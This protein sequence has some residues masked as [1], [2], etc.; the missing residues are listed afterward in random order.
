LFVSVSGL[1]LNTVW[2]GFNQLDTF[3]S[4]AHT[5]CVHTNLLTSKWC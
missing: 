1:F 5:N 3:G 4:H 2:T